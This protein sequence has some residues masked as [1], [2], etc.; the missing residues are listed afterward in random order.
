MKGT[1]GYRSHRCQLFVCVE[2]KV[3]EMGVDR[4]C[5]LL[6]STRKVTIFIHH[7]N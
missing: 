2:V 7:A 1:E 5:S 4:M 6:L 3:V